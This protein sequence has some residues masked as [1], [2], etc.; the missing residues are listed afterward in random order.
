[1][2]CTFAFLYILYKVRKVVWPP[3]D[4]PANIP[5]IPFYVTFVGPVLGWDQEKV[6]NHFYR[7]KLETHGAVKVYFASTWNVLVTKPE[8]LAQILRSNDI[9][10]KSG[11]QEKIPH[12]VLS[13][14]TGDNVIS[15]GNRNW[16]L[17]RKIITDS[18][19]FPDLA[20]LQQN[21]QS[22]IDQLRIAKR[23]L[24]VAQSVQQLTLANIGDCVL[25]VDLH[26]SNQGGRAI[27][28][29]I[30]EVKS[31]IFRPLFMSFPY[32]DLLPIPSR[33]RARNAVRSFKK[34]YCDKI[35]H[36]ITPENINRL[37]PKLASSFN[38][39]EIT[40]KQFQDN[41]IIALVAGHENPQLLLT[42]LMY[43]LAKYRH[44]QISLREELAT[45]EDHELSPLLTAVIYETLRMY[46]PLGQIINRKTTCKVVLGDNIII[47]KGTYVGYNNYG[48]QRDP[49]YWGPNSDLF[50]PS[51]WGSTFKK[52]QETYS[53]SKSRCTLPAFHGRKRACLG[54]KFAL[55]QMR[56]TIAAVVEQFDLS[57][58]P[59]WV[60]RMTLAGPICPLNLTLNAVPLGQG[61]KSEQK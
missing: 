41:A 37:G 3:S 2:C 40:E 32:L 13:E 55:M 34:Q 47:P 23:P 7:E 58:A 35:V 28:E 52:I 15:A 27:Y 42:S 4:F 50:I 36:E 38:K 25:G 57:L 14:Y 29:R 5:T 22:F 43:V 49:K 11:N 45:L 53:L 12:S 48:T 59:E 6:Y 16:K 31:Q 26:T 19:L 10:E 9:F 1:M 51:R 33:V 61:K 20:P 18:I 54:E 46:P 24:N 21:I 44:I 39:G 30:R 17:Y 8:Y 56:K 60:E